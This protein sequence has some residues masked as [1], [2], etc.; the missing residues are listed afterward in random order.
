MRAVW[1]VNGRM[2]RRYCFFWTGWKLSKDGSEGSPAASSYNASSLTTRAVARRVDCDTSTTA[3]CSLALTAMSLGTSADLMMTSEL[4]RISFTV[5]ATDASG[6]RARAKD[7]Q[8][9]LDITPPQ[10]PPSSVRPR[11]A[12]RQTVRCVVQPDLA[13]SARWLGLNWDPALDF[14]IVLYR[15]CLGTE[16]HPEKYVKCRTLPSALS[17]GFTTADLVA[18]PLV[19]SQIVGTVEA[20]NAAGLVTRL[21]TAAVRVIFRE[22]DAT[23]WDELRGVVCV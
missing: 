19:D 3:V 2:K 18:V 4:R 6:E 7:V 10:W 14:G 16:L 9:I 23:C 12:F 11:K 5:T 1:L 13:S 17:V 21:R 20:V 15:A 8:L 22:N